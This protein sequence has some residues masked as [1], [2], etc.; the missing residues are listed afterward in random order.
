MVTLLHKF[1]NKLRPI[2]KL[3]SLHQSEP[4]TITA[5]LSWHNLD[6]IDTDKLL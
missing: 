3:F 5:V 1:V 4:D 6:P 2:S